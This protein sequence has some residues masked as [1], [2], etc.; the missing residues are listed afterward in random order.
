MDLSLGEKLYGHFSTRD[1]LFLATVMETPPVGMETF[2]WHG[3]RHEE[4]LLQSEISAHLS[5]AFSYRMIDVTKLKQAA[6][7]YKGCCNPRLTK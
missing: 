6:A 3:G 2:S 7:L 4:V 1:N 5:D